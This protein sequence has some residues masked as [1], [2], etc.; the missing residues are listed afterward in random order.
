MIQRVANYLFLATIFFLPWQ[1]QL[2]LERATIEGEPSQYGVFGFYVVEVMI[3]AAFLL[4]GRPIIPNPAR[5]IVKA[6]FLF[7]AAGFFSLTLSSLGTIGWLH[8]TH[9][10]SAAFLFLLLIDERTRLKPVMIALLAGLSIPLAIGWLQI[11]TGAS[12]ESTFLGIASKQAQTAG[13][14]VVETLDGRTLRAYGTFSHPNIF[15]GYVAVGIV[16]LAWLTRFARTRRDLVLALVAS[17]VLAA[18]LIITFSRSAWLALTLAFITLIVLMLRNRRLPPRRVFPMMILGL[19]VLF[20][21]T[22]FFHSQVFSRFNPSQRVEAV[23]IEERVSQY[24]EFGQVF[25]SAPV[26]GVGP[27]AYTFTRAL[28]DPGRA[29]W[30][31]QPIHNTILLILSE[32]GIIGFIFFAH[33]IYQ[34]DMLSHA[35][36]REPN[37]MFALALGV[38]LLVIAFFDH[39]LWSLWPGLALSVLSLAIMAK[40]SYN[41]SDSKGF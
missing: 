30:E 39:Y 22:A 20:S 17:A 10:V 1:T 2:I 11:F 13:V 27:N 25:L 35:R 8:V 3:T 9:V 24:K 38:A 4:R 37:G 31:Y 21:T 16:V 33:W 15:G 5:R 14:A 29:V 18:T 6:F 36:W 34:I 23:S 32:L 26:F 28:L 40:W 12:F 7:L 19:I 41:T